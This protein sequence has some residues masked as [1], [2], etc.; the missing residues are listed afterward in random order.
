MDMA[1][2]LRYTAAD[3]RKAFKQRIYDVLIRMD[4]DKYGG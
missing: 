4:V 1:Y 3:T 2:V